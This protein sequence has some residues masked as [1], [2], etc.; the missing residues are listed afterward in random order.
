MIPP[1]GESTSPP[2]NEYECSIDPT[3]PITE[4]N[5]MVICH[6]CLR[7]HLTSSVKVTRRPA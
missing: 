7:L 4:E 3:H 2:R 6:T 5:H 1:V